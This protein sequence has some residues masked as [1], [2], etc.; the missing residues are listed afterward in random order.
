MYV[1]GAYRV[2]DY[3]GFCE[4]LY[5]LPRVKTKFPLYLRILLGM[6]LGVGVG[7]LAVWTGFGRAVHDWVGPFGVI[8]IRLLKLVAVPLVF[9]SLIKGIG[10]LQDVKRLSHLGLK[11]LAIYIATTVFAILV[12]VGMVSWIRPGAVFSPGQA[13]QIRN[14][15]GETVGAS[16]QSASEIGE[17][18]PLQFLVDIV[19]ENFFAALG[20]NGNMLQIIFIALLCGVAI[21]A[22][23]RKTTA[24]V[25]DV[26][27][28]LNEIV[29]R[30]IHYAM[31]FA[32]YGVL[33]LMADLVVGFGGDSAIF[34]ALGLYILTVVVSLAILIFLF[35]PALLKL[36]TRTPI[37]KFFRTIAPAQLLAFSTSS[38][39][40]T[41]PV[42]MEQVEKGLGVS[43]E[44]AS[45]VLPVGVTINMDG[46]SCYQAVA[47]FFIGQVLGIE[48][49][50]T[51]TLTIIFMTVIS[52][53][54]TPGIPGGSIVILMMVLDSVGISGEW[55]ALV[56]GV[57]RP[58]DMMRTVV[59]VTGDTVVAQ[60][61][62]S[63]V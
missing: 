32:P 3:L 62:D 37:G 39:A 11:T 55:L 26:V 12:G 20:S 46:T 59:N 21:V 24:P 25:M 27:E 4:I 43:S 31:L 42:T 30:I 35:Y 7:L 36:F 10:H 17:A 61:I 19:P 14:S 51:Q 44:V 1:C 9:L 2:R 38:S 8:F 16:T 45:F 48:F 50:L 54:G 47:V 60:I 6:V 22:L 49:T 58:L 33:A 53:I 41:L 28:G 56:L 23:P 57:D 15:Y 18:G 29:L 40:A 5:I 13:E 63:R 52:S 34:G